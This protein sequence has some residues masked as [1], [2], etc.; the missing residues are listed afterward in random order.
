MIYWCAV[1]RG[2]DKERR[3]A[4][5]TNLPLGLHAG[6]Q[7]ELQRSGPSRHPQRRAP[8]DVESPPT[9]DRPLWRLPVCE[10]NKCIPEALGTRSLT[11]SK[12][13]NL[14]NQSP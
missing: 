2:L 10:L 11:C 3:V 5:R 4:P 7:L 14:F 13:I 8:V 1:R 9:F 12:A 6:S